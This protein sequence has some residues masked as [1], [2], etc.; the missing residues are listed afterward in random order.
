MDRSHAPSTRSQSH[1]R[2]DTPTRT[3][4]HARPPTHDGHAERTDTL[5]IGGGQAG[6]ATAY[7]LTRR[8]VPCLVLDAS[9]RVGDVWRERWESLRLFTPARYDGLPGMPFPAPPGS[10]PTKDAMADYLEAYAERFDLPLR[11][12]QRVRRLARDGD[13]FVA[14]T[15]D[16]RYRAD[17]VVVAMG[18]YQEPR[19]P[20][21]AAELDR[22]LLQ[23]HSKAYRSPAQLPDGP[24]LLV[25]AGNSGAEIAMEVVRTRPTYLAGRSPG[26]LPFRVDGGGVSPLLRWLTLRVV[27]HRLVTLRTPIGRAVRRRLVGRAGPLIRQ[28]VGDLDRAGVRRVPRVVGARDGRP[29]LEDGRVLDVASVIWCTGYHAGFSWIDLPMPDEHELTHA[30][31][32]TGPMP[33]VHV[34][35]PHL[36]FA[37]SSGMIQGV[38]RDAARVARAVVAERRRNGAAERAPLGAP[39]RSAG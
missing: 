39:A 16:G 3:D 12:G 4:T 30:R 14:E 33:G 17:R 26:Q 15:E 25:G 2:P 9:E 7:E 36:A 27:F 5:V 35:G 22:S 11:L 21:I 38:G 13:G 6:L 23:L 31:G 29:V 1:T 18:T 19:V 34:V 37:L 32:A 28:R 24:V 10:F 8:G 20:A